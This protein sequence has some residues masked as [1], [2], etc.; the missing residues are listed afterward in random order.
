[1]QWTDGIPLH[2]E[3]TAG[4]AG[5]KFLRGLKSGKILAGYCPNCRE[6][7]LP[8]RIYCVRCYGK[9]TKYVKVDPVARVA[10][11][12]STGRDGVEGSKFAF[13]KFKGV[14]GGMIHRLIGKARVGNKVTPLFKPRSERKGSILD[15][16]GFE[17][18]R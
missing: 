3:Y 6:V 5:E 14:S 10:A 1:M 9:I 8:P 11:I 15:I 18:K 13:I 12:T 16:Q 2:Y 17:S 7:S 4:V